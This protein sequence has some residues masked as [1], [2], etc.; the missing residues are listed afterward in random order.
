MIY[1]LSYKLLLL[2]IYRQEIITRLQTSHTIVSLVT[3]NLSKYM[4]EVRKVAQGKTIYKLVKKKSY[5]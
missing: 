2:H 4:D 3:D 1:I 5:Y